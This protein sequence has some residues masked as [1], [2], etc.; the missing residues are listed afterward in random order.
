MG[1]DEKVAVLQISDRRG[2]RR[3]REGIG[4]EK[5]FTSSVAFAKA[6]GERGAA[7][8]TDQEI[9]LALENQGERKSPLE[10]RHAR[11]HGLDRAEAATHRVAHQM[12]NDFRVGFG[13]KFMTLGL[14]FGAE[15][16]KILDDPVVHD[17][18]IGI[19]V[20]MRVVFGWPSMRRPAGVADSNVPAERFGGEANLQIF[21]LSA[22]PATGQPARFQ[23]RDASGIITAIFEPLEP[24]QNR[25]RNRPLA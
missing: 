1:Q 6:H 11:S 4:A 21:E 15:F 24:F 18:D 3:K 2:E 16:A 13:Q 9:V 10:P 20:R 19:D 23:S 22:H 25:S 7:A 8:G 5:H 12:G 14:Q 17:P